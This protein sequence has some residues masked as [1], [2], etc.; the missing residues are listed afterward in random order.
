MI[1]DIAATHSLEDLLVHYSRLPHLMHSDG[2]D[3]SVNRFYFN[4]VT[5]TIMFVIVAVTVSVLLLWY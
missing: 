3:R 2:T 1:L 4:F 5:I